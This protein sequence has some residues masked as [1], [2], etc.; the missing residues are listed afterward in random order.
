MALKYF[1]APNDPRKPGWVVAGQWH[2]R[3]AEGDVTEE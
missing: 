1:H 3:E 2:T